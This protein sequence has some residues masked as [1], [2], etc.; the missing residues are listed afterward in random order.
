VIEDRKRR[1]SKSKK[2]TSEDEVEAIVGKKTEKGKVL[3]NVKWKGF[4]DDDNTWEPLSNLSNCINLVEAFDSAEEKG[5]SSSSTRRSSRRSSEMESVKKKSTTSHRRSPSST[6]S[7][8]S[9]VSKK[10]KNVDK[11][12]TSAQVVAKRVSS[13]TNAKNEDRLGNLKNVVR[14][15]GAT[16]KDKDGLK[17]LVE[18]SRNGVKKESWVDNK[19]AREHIPKLLLDFY[20]SNVR[21]E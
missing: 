17:F 10:K 5:K 2:T 8:H 15:L 20:E 21:F 9:P 7:H 19:T 4:D 12:S 1:M 16:D 6:S 18:T 13:Q 14:V 3:Y 11:A